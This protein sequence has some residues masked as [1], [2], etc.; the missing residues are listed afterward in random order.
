VFEVISTHLG[1]CVAALCFFPRAAYLVLLTNVVLY[2]GPNSRIGWAGG[3][4]R[5]SQIKVCV[6]FGR[7]GKWTKGVARWGELRG[8]GRQLWSSNLQ[9]TEVTGT[10]RCSK[11]G[12]LRILHIS[13]LGLL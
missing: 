13:T 9:G 8:G 12:F 10:F 7:L 3:F 5:P 11:S 1:C 6:T 2:E 4:S